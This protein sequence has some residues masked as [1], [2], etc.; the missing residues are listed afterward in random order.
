MKTKLISSLYTNQSLTIV[1]LTDG[2]VCTD[3]V[4]SSHANWKDVIKAYQAKDYTK[5]VNLLNVRRAI[6]T[7]SQGKFTVDCDAVLY[8]GEPVSGFLF[9]KIIENLKAGMPFD[10][11]LKFADNLWQNPSSRARKELYTFLENR[12]YT[13]DE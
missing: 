5:M 7:K 2:K 10:N 8:N 13:I 6:C 1:H 12:N 3:I 9:N 11:L 4:Q